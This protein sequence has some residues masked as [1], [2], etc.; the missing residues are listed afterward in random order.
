MPLHD[1]NLTIDLLSGP[2]DTPT[3]NSGDS[4]WPPIGMVSCY[5]SSSISSNDL[6]LSIFG[7]PQ[8]SLSES[9][10]MLF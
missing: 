1:L 6:D 2:R 3:M 9:I 4:I 5:F 10:M 7:R 8:I